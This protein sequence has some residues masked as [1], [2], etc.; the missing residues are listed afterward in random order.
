MDVWPDWR[1]DF[2]P[3]VLASV[4]SYL[5]G[6][7]ALRLSIAARILAWLADHEILEPA[8][9]GIRLTYLVGFPYLALLAGGASPRGMGLTGLDWVHTL[10][11]GVPLAMAAWGVILIAWRQAHLLSPD[12]T[13]IFHRNTRAAGWLSAA[14]EAGAQQMHWAFYR[15]AWVR[16]WDPYWG[17]W[18]SLLTLG[19]EW[20][21]G[22]WI[23]RS[24]RVSLYP[25][26]VH[27]LLAF[28]TTALYLTVPNWWLNWG[29][30]TLTLLS[31]RTAIAI[32]PA[33][34][35]SQSQT[36]NG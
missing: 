36:T 20:I 2:S 6:V 22:S 25:L 9:W 34:I 23:W 30:H 14:L 3:W 7:Q 18:A 8:W 32:G 27:A 31:T 12:S 5:L 28:I 15:D 35:L 13:L 29:L 17:A 11:L 33:Q 21:S 26:M 4:L 19:L 24:K 16:W 10:G 1:V